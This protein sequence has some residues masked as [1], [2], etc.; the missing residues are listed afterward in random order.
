MVEKNKKRVICFLL[1]FFIICSI[2]RIGNIYILSIG[3]YSKKNV[4]AASYI[5]YHLIKDI[6]GVSGGGVYREYG[7]FGIALKAGYEFEYVNPGMWNILGAFDIHN[8]SDSVDDLSFNISDYCVSVYLDD[9]DITFYYSGESENDYANF[10]VIDNEI[11]LTDQSYSAAI[12]EHFE[13]LDDIIV[14][15]EEIIGDY[16]SIMN[17]FCSKAIAFEMIILIICII[18][19]VLLIMW[20]RKNSKK[21]FDKESVKLKKSNLKWACVETQMYGFIVELIITFLLSDGSLTG[22]MIYYIMFFTPVYIV[23]FIVALVVYFIRKRSLNKM[24]ISDAENI[25]KFRVEE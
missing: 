9:Q 20:Y 14:K 12:E 7:D 18:L 24:S 16:K 25:S 21:L 11:V 8:F 6:E 3:D 13:V 19:I 23:T 1:V 15:S 5:G 10:K 2:V 4:Y 22:F 17:Q